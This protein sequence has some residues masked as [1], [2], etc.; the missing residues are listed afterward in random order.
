MLNVYT[1]FAQA[2]YSSV[3]SVQTM[4]P[5]GSEKQQIQAFSI[6]AFI[7]T[8]SVFA[9][10]TLLGAVSIQAQDSWQPVWGMDEADQSMALAYNVRKDVYSGNS[11]SAV[12]HGNRRKMPDMQQC[13]QRGDYW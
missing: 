1:A 2:L 7:K 5:G 3:N 9:M 11:I 4:N 12:W 13:N 10:L 6:P 8:G